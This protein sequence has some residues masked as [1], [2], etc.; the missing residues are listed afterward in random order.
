MIV[1]AMEFHEFDDC[2]AFMNLLDDREFVFK[3]KHTL[4]SKFEEMVRWFLSDYMGLTTR[5][6]PP[7][8][9][10]KKKNR[11]IKSIYTGGDRR[12][13]PGSHYRKLVACICKRSRI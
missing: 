8:A 1:K 10:N 11:L 2:K 4:E 5:P 13:L 12:R 3:Y 9:P 6:I 7:F